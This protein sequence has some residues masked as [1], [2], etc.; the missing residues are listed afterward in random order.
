LDREY[1]QDYEQREKEEYNRLVETRIQDGTF[2]FG[3]DRYPPCERFVNLQEPVA[4][5]TLHTA[6]EKNLW[7]QIP[8]TGSLIISIPSYPK[9]M[10]EEHLFPASEIP[11]IIRFIK[12]TGKLQIVLHDQPTCYEGLDHMD[13]F[14][15]ELKPPFYL[16]TP[17]SVFGNEKEIQKNSEVFYTLGSIKYF[18]FLRKETE[19][20][21]S[22][23]FKLIIQRTLSTYLIL[24]LSRYDAIVQAI[25]KYMI[26]DPA[27]AFV[28]FI[29]CQRFITVPIND[30]LCDSINLTLEDARTAQYLPFVYRPQYIQ[31][32]CE[33][34]KFLL[35]KLT[36]AAQDMRACYSL[37]DDYDSYDLRRVQ[38]SLNEGIVTNDPDIVTKSAKEFSIILDN[39]WNDKTI[40]NRIK[41]IEIGVPVSIAAIGGIV[42]G[43]PGL[44]AGGFLSE[45]GFKVAEKATEKYAEKLFSIKG[46]GLTERL[47][48]LRM[49][50]YQANI[51]DFKKK[52]K[53]RI[54]LDS[55]KK[56]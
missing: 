40:P 32:P 50:S 45:L 36:Y 3:K 27:K 35:R 56:L 42:A 38:E 22:S 21:Y 11:E 19:Q 20:F 54:V 18:D 53:H 31:F 14:F 55:K 43:L 39:I 16:A 15:K 6:N 17:F 51:Y 9:S 49:K 7:A 30:L 44:F 47:V 5:T 46:E 26:D 28:L 2:N 8:F 41:N 29:V 33:I 25:E 13:P 23:S 4:L 52:Y 34:G 12:E 10:F 37:M 1:L 48:K 24:K